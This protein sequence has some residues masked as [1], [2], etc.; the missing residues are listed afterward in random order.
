MSRLH[1][2]VER[3]LVVCACLGSALRAAQL[4]LHASQGARGGLSEPP[5][6][7]L[8]RAES[9]LLFAKAELAYLGGPVPAAALPATERVL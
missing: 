2:L 6:V 7:W 8:A 9:S 5:S 4:A 3:E 1:E